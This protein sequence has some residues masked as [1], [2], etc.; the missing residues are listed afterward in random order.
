MSFKYR[1]ARPY[2][3]S[4]RGAFTPTRKWRPGG[5][6]DGSMLR[7][8]YPACLRVSTRFIKPRPKLSRTRSAGGLSQVVATQRIAVGN[9][10]APDALLACRR[11]HVLERPQEIDYVLLLR[12]AQSIETLDDLIGL[13]ARA[14]VELDSFH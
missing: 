3:E 1:R 12:S 2:R 13:A 4:P 8:Q 10:P 14:L 6:R 7:E 9:S 5:V 11:P